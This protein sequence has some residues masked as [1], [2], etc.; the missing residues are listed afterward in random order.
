MKPAHLLWWLVLPLALNAPLAARQVRAD[1][2]RESL[3]RSAWFQNVN[4]ELEIDAY[5]FAPVSGE[6]AAWSASNRAHGFAGRVSAAGLVLEP[7]AADSSNACTQ[8]KLELSTRSFGRVGH[9]SEVS[10][11]DVHV[12]ERRAEIDRGEILEWFVNDP[13]GVEHGW[14][15]ER[16]TAG[17]EPLW[18]GLEL[19]G[20]LSLRIDADSRSGV[21]VDATGEPRLRYTGLVAFD[22]T[23]R[24]L[25]ARMQPSPD[26]VGIAIDDTSAVYPLTVDPML[27]FPMWT[28]ESDQ[29]AAR[30]GQ[31]AATAGDVNGDGYSDVIVGARLYHNGESEEGRAY[32]YLGSSA[33]LSVSAHWT[34]EGNQISAKFGTSVATAGDVNGD[35]YSDVI[36]GAY[37]ADDG[38]DIHHLEGRAY[39]YMGSSTGLSPTAAWIAEG[40]QVAVR[41][42]YCVATAGDVNGDGYSDVLVGAPQYKN[43]QAAE[44]RAFLYLGSAA[45]ISS[46]AAWTAEGDQAFASFGLSVASA[47]DVN[48]DGYDDAIV[49]APSYD[50]DQLQE[51][52]VFVYL[53]SSA[54]LSPTAAWTAE[55]NQTASFFGGSTATAGDV[56]GDGYSDVIVGAQHFD[57]DQMGEGTSFVYLGS[58]SGLGA[59]AAWTA[60]GNQELAWFGADVSTAGDVNGDGYSDVIVGAIGASN[61]QNTEGRAFIYFGGE[62]GL[63]LAPDWVGESDQVGAR[64]GE[65]AAFAGDVNG[66]G[67]S[68]VI[69]GAYNYDSHGHTDEGRAFVY[70]GA[71]D[72]LAVRAFPKIEIDQANAGFGQ[73]V[74]T[75]G[76]VNGDGFSDVIVGASSYDHGQFDEGGAFVYMGSAAGLSTSIAWSTEGNQTAANLGFSAVSAGDVDGD[77]YS[78]VIVGASRYDATRGIAL[79]FLGSSAGLSSTAASTLESAFDSAAFG[80]SVASAGDVDG[81]GYGDVI[82]GADLLSHGEQYEG[83]AFLFMGSAAGLSLKPAWTA[84]SDQAG[85][86]FG[87]KVAT[88]GDV[89]GDGY[90]DVIIGAIRYDDGQMFEGHAF[91]YMGSPDGLATEAAWTTEGNQ[92][93]AQLGWSVASAGD[94][95]A[96]GFSDV[97]VGAIGYSN[98]ETREGRAFLYLGS[99]A[100]LS[101]TAA[102]TGES[103]QAEARF[104]FS[105]AS[106]GDVNCDGYGD[107]VVSQLELGNSVADQGRTYVYLGS[108]TGLAASPAWTATGDEPVANFGYS[109]ATAGDVNGDG[110]SDV[111]VGAA[112]DDNGQFDEGRA[113]VYHGNEGRGGWTLAPQQ[114]R[115]NDAAPIA[116]LGRSIDKHEFRIRVDLERDLAGFAWAS[117]IAPT[118]RLEW[119][120]APLRVPLDGSHIESGA[121]QPISRTP[122]TFNELVEFHSNDAVSLPIGSAQQLAAGAYHWRARIRTNNPLFPVTPWTTVPWNNVGETKLRA[123]TLPATRVPH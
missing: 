16:A 89:N 55:S 71:A 36:V 97:I 66:D 25:Q 117:G 85:A 118:A 80:T 48:R 103:N 15:I 112:R 88:A 54:G 20:D 77:G 65:A 11:G 62:T 61:G 114:R 32:V 31:F 98:G 34:A 68:D 24:E 69:V 56:N 73:S 109:V 78:D 38:S 43:G 4:A 47:G 53:G 74:A 93:N 28:A 52:R 19:K 33:G 82:C 58:S 105:V 35:G 8:W 122:L 39:L 116:L 90:S 104:G 99:S 108:S 51:G 64:F 86:L 42:G 9:A 44:G 50:N 12:T 115:S 87:G 18:I 27:T 60:E 7:L 21:L 1:A 45:G 2:S 83:A 13:R 121:E 6:P 40:N 100:G 84:E 41:F 14:T 49:S 59:A 111:I 23:G 22:A 17:A 102:W 57:N 95:N 106:A 81:D 30:F 91:V 72:G 5:R 119:E 63:S 26:G 3:E 10:P 101:S 113:F 46:I 37:D 67:Y 120:V 75:A 96:D 94:V 92:Q 123:G 76:D 107:V 29:D 110:Y 79:V 70:H